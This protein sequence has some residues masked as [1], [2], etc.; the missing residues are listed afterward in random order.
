M[1]KNPQ[2]IVMSGRT[3]YARLVVFETLIVALAAAGMPK[4]DEE[5]NAFLAELKKDAAARALETGYTEVR[6]EADAY[7]DEIFAAIAEA[8]AS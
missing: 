8:A 5:R 1:A 4:T 7:T 2:P 3:L 6:E